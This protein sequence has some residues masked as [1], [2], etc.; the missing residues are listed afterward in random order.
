ML[1]LFQVEICNGSVSKRVFVWQAY[2]TIKRRY[3]KL[4][5]H[6]LHIPGLQYV[7]LILKTVY[8]T[9]ETWSRRK[10]CNVVLLTSVCLSPA[11]E[12]TRLDARKQTSNESAFIQECADL[13]L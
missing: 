8:V 10:S 7:L 6:D 3:A 9:V 11:V 5:I 2:S 4:H 13:Q 1:P 12:N